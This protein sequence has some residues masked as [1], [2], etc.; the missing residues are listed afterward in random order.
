[1]RSTFG[2]RK[3]VLSTS[4]RV[5]LTLAI[6]GETRFA[7]ESSVSKASVAAHVF[8]STLAPP[9][10]V[11]RGSGEKCIPSA[12]FH[13]HLHPSI[14]VCVCVCASLLLPPVFS[15]MATFGTTASRQ[16]PPQKPTWGCRRFKC[17]PLAQNGQMAKWPGSPGPKPR[18]V[19]WSLWSPSCLVIKALWSGL[20]SGYGR[21]GRVGGLLGKRSDHSDHS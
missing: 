11:H 4:P 19:L 1:M 6:P 2:P 8:Q 14:S 13:S 5:H 3:H 21:Y 17:P 18:K 7:H 12:F 10:C 20:W 15:K 9:H 16:A